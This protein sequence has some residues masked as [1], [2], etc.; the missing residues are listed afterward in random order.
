MRIAVIGPQNTGKSTFISDFVNKFDRYITPKESYRDFIDKEEIPINQ[1]TTEE[2]QRF[3]R[4]FI[5][6]QLTTNKDK[7]IIFDRSIVDNYVYTLAQFEKGIIKKDFLKETEGIM[8]ES[9][10]KIDSLIFIPTAASVKI[11]NDNMRDTDVLSIDA[12]NRMFIATLLII[13][14]KH[15]IKIVTIAGGRDDRIKQVESKLDL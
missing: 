12:I 6:K 15:P 9:F 13:T 3:I 8:Y 4:D 14:S 11:I 7:K 5:F 1:E 10:S 2:S